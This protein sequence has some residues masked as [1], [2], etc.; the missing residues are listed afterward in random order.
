MK[1]LYKPV[2]SQYTVKK[3]SLVFVSGNI[4]FETCIKFAV[5]HCSVFLQSSR[6]SDLRKYAILSHMV[7]D[8]RYTLL[9]TNRNTCISSTR[10]II[11]TMNN[12]RF[13]LNH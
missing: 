10:T 5:D 1:L 9:Q 2:F 8:S 7:D 4:K 3:S 11:T 6:D 12:G 13:L